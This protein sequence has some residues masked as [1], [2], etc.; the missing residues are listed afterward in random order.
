MRKTAPRS[1]ALTLAIAAMGS[2]GTLAFMTAPA[3][4]APAKATS[5]YAPSAL[6]LTVTQGDSAA[7]APERA[8]TLSCTPTATGTHP[9]A[10]TACEQLR[11]AGGD[12]DALKSEGDLYCT[13]E[14]RPVVVTAQGVWEGKRVDHERTYANTCVK[15]VEGSS[16]FAF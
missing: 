4:A 2:L 7:A 8:V 3:Q 6:V 15:N 1:T 14:W 9:A 12:F 10:D 5:L 11:A 13:R 16:V